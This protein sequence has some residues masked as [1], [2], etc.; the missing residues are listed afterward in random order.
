MLPITEI[1]S[2]GI[3]II[4]KIIPD[5]EAKEKAQKEFELELLRTLQNTDNQQA[6]INKAEAQH[7]NIFVAGWRPFIGWVCGAAFC[8]QYILYPIL[9][10]AIAFR[11]PDIK[12]PNI[13]TDNIFELTMAMLGL[14]GLRTFEKVKLR[15]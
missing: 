6:E 12:L 7:Q 2:G 10:W 9:S 8:W 4:D 13:N 14:G 3:K 5:A 1:I 15:K 11:Y